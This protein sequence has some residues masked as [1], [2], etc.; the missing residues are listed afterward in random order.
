MGEGVALGMWRRTRAAEV[1]YDWMSLHQIQ[2]LLRGLQLSVTGK[3][4]ILVS[5][6]VRADRKE[7]LPS[8]YLRL[9]L[10]RCRLWLWLWL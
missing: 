3:R 6:V 4:D 9:R 5:W 7:L 8:D 2:E 10:G 1:F